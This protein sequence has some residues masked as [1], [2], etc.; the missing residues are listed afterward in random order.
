M[1]DGL[2][3]HTSVL[4]KK[5]KEAYG[6]HSMPW[7]A[8]SPD[9]NPIENG[10]NTLKAALRRRFHQQEKRPHSA[11]ELFKAAQEEQEK[12]PQAVLDRWVDNFSDRLKACLK[13]EGGH[14]K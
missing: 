12:I 7:P 11:E 10:Q 14:T 3:V 4:A 5:C 9:L 13:A 2:Q 1:E 6:I 8:N